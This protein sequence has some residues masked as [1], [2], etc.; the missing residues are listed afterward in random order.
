MDSFGS[1]QERTKQ[2]ERARFLGY[3]FVDLE[4]ITVNGARSISFRPS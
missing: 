4:R 3:A 2:M 1:M